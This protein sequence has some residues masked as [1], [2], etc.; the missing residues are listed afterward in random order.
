MRSKDEEKLISIISVAIGG[1]G[2][3]C[4]FVFG[5]PMSESDWVWARNLAPFVIWAGIALLLFYV[6]LFVGNSKIAKAI[7]GQ[8]ASQIT[9][10]AVAW[11]IYVLASVEAS[12]TLNKT[13]GVDAKAFPIAHEVLTFLH[14][15]V[16]GEPVFVVL[17]VWGL[18][19]VIYY[20]ATGGSGKNGS[21]PTLIFACSGSVIGLVSLAAINFTLEEN[22]LDKKAYFIARALDFNDNLNCPGNPLSGHGVFLGPSQARI[23]YDELPLQLDWS[24][25]VYANAKELENLKMPKHLSIIE[26]D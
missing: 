15:F 11:L 1:L 9:F 19:T 8:F 7:G 10:A 14:M 6:F 25:A 2:F 4:V 13:F 23:L 20:A 12:S 18:V 22:T 24:Q 21:I 5:A 17:L 16:F 3:S 26:C